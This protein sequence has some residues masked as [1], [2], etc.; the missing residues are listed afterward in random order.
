MNDWRILIYCD[1]NGCPI[2]ISKDL[3]AFLELMR[4]PE[5]ADEPSE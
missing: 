5:F 2:Y 4:F 1:D 3:D